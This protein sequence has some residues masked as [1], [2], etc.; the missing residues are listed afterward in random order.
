M[1]FGQPARDR[2]DWPRRRWSQLWTLVLLAPAAL[3]VSS[4]SA[5]MAAATLGGGF[6]VAIVTV[7]AMTAESLQASPSRLPDAIRFSVRA[8]VT[9]VGF[10]GVVAH[11]PT[12]ALVMFAAY[13]TTA[14]WAT[15]T[16]STS[17]EDAVATPHEPE[18]REE[19]TGVSETVTTD[20]VRTMTDA[21]LC[22]AWR[23]S[24]V[25][26]GSTPH[27]AR[28]ANVVSLR[29]VILDEIEL[30][31]S[32]GLH[33]WLHS[34]ARAASGPDRFLVSSKETRPPTAA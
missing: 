13:V 10:A 22:L 5:G 3:T 2:D 1:Q 33:A 25:T 8:V 9:C 6:F 30:R 34:G 14:S 23:R 15:L 28:R 27:P 21:E 19:A 18:T 29:Q 26:L 4:M 20:D 24:F 31:D 12:L 17:P 11:A 16:R 32:V 7:V